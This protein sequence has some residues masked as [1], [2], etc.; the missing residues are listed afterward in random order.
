LKDKFLF[1][2]CG[3]YRHIDDGRWE[4]ERGALPEALIAIDCVRLGNFLGGLFGGV[5]IIGW[6]GRFGNVF[7]ELCGRCGALERGVR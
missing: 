2:P 5:R 4:G 7:Y 3:F 1:K 6:S